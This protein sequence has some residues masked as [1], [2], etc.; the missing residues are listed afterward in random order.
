MKKIFIS[1]LLISFFAAADAQNATLQQYTGKYKFPDGSVVTE[2]EVTL[3]SSG[4][5]TSNS[6]AGT[7]VL[8]KAGTD[9]FSVVSFQGTAV[10][11]RDANKKITGVVIDA[12]GYHLEGIKDNAE[13]M[14]L[15]QFTGKYKFP[16]GSVVTEITVTIEDG[17][18]TSNST[19]GTSVLE[20][21]SADTFSVVSFQGTA[22]FKRDANH[23]VT[24]VV[25]DA[26]GYHLEGTKDNASTSFLFTKPDALKIKANQFAVR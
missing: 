7:S 16:D 2:I 25:V 8:E 1:F 24:G 26:M 18:L 5:L 6:T 9:T 23:K 20:K 21:I 19:A 22:V 14:A 10:F 11:K 4:V 17:V 3:D 15:Q 13:A 12:M